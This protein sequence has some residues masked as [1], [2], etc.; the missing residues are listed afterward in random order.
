[1]ITVE[2]LELLTGYESGVLIYKDNH[3]TL[4]GEVINWTGTFGL[5][6]FFQVSCL[7]LGETMKVNNITNDAG[8]G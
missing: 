1:M 7:G 8:C 6:R 4:K 2:S 5:P 3:G